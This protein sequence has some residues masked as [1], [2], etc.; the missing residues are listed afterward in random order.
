[1]VA[2]YRWLEALRALDPHRFA[3]SRLAD[4]PMECSNSVRQGLLNLCPT[5]ADS[6]CGFLF[7]V[8]ES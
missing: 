8:S 2:A 3:G 4:E 5:G 6:P 1:V 7:D